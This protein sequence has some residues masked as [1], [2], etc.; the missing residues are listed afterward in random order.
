M[1]LEGPRREEAG[2]HAQTP[3]SHWPGDLSAEELVLS[4]RPQVLGG[5]TVA[6]RA[7]GTSTFFPR[8]VSFSHSLMSQSKCFTSNGHK[9]EQ[10]CF[11]QPHRGGSYQAHEETPG[12]QG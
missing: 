7:S 8:R 6:S 12:R 3:R 11:L 1:L 9:M 5:C 10:T 4:G 2:P